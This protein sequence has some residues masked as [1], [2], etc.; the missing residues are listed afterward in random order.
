MNEC[1]VCRPLRWHSFNICD[2]TTVQLS[3]GTVHKFLQNC[4][5]HENVSS[6]FF[7]ILRYVRAEMNVHAF[8]NEFDQKDY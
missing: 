8:M 1:C 6:L 7:Y 4:T 5:S 3:N 2:V